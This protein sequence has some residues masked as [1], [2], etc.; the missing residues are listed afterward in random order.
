MAHRWVGGFG[1]GCEYKNMAHSNVFVKLFCPSFRPV[2]LR[3][4]TLDAAA[5]G[6]IGADHLALGW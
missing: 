1:E 5:G 4:S 6:V 3:T 2:R